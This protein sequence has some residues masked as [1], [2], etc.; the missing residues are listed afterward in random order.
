MKVYRSAITGEYVTE[1]YALANPDTTVSEDVEDG[2]EPKS[3]IIITPNPV[4]PQQP[5]DEPK[6][7]PPPEPSEQN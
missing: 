3:V 2:C 4:P 1:E 7:D 6:D 5:P